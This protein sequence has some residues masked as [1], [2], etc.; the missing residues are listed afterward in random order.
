MGADL[1]INNSFYR[2]RDRDNEGSILPE[3]IGCSRLLTRSEIIEEIEKLM[4]MYMDGTS[5]YSRCDIT[6]AIRA[7]TVALDH[8]KSGKLCKKGLRQKFI[9]SGVCKYKDIFIREMNEYFYVFGYKDATEDDKTDFIKKKK[10]E[11]QRFAEYKK[12]I[13][14][15]GY[16]YF[17]FEW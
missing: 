3:L 10:E 6:A 17:G 13:M 16:V 2:N 5:E 9:D 15:D 7:F 8:C 14:T 4:K 11:E 1:W 12:K